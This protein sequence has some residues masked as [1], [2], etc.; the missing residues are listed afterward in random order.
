LSIWIIN[1]FAKR[2]N[3]LSGETQLISYISLSLISYDPPFRIAS[4]YGA[5]IKDSC[6]WLARTIFVSNL[7]ALCIK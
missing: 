4:K 6:F 7:E 5:I 1:L 2:P 3:P